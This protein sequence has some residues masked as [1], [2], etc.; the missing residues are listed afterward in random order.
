MKKQL[1][2][3]FAAVAVSTVF[4]QTASPSWS[5]SQNAAFTNTA[6]GIRIIDAVDANVVWL[7]G[8][9]GTAPS[10]NYSWFSRTTN[11]GTTFTAGTIF[12]DTNNYVI[13]NMEG[14]DAN[15]AWVCA[16]QHGAPYSVANPGGGGIF[17]TTNGGT[18][19]VN[20]AP[21]GMLT[22]TAQSFADFVSFLTPSVGIFVGD[23]VG[24]SYEIWRT[25]SGGN[26][27]TQVPA[28]AI[29]APVNST[30]FAITNL[31]CK[32]GNSNL[33]F[34]TN[35]GRVYRTTDGGSSWAVSQVAAPTSTI[36]QLAFTTPSV[37]LVYAYNGTTTELWN[38][39]DGG[40]TWAQVSPVPANMGL[41]DVKAIP[42]TN[43]YVSADGSQTAPFISYSSNNGATWTDFGSTGIQYLTLDFANPTSGWVGSFSDITT[44]SLGG[45]WKYSGTLTAT[46]VAPTSAFAVNPTLCGPTGAVTATN[47]ST[48]T[49]PLSYT[50]SVAPST[51]ATIS[52]STSAAPS[53]NFTAN[54]SYTLTLV[55]T[56]SVGTN[57]SSQ[58]VDVITC[59]APT[60]SFT[61]PTDACNLISF[62]TTVSGTPGSPAAGYL[63][64]ASPSA[65]VTF[66]PSPAVPNPSIKAIT[67]GTYTIT[68][69]ASNQS[70][71]VS[72]TQTVTVSDCKP[73]PSF[74]IAAGGCKPDTL[75]AANT[76]SNIAGTTVNSYTWTTAP[77]AGVVRTNTNSPTGQS[78]R[79]IFNNAN[80]YTI[81]LKA[82]NASGTAS[83]VQVI[84]VVACYV[85]IEENTNLANLLN[86]YPN[87][88]HDVLNIALP[89]STD[90]YTVKL[91]NVL[92]AVVYE[93]KT[94][95]TA[96]VSINLANKAKGVYFLN[97]ETNTEKVTKKVIVE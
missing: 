63:W 30:E 43:I 59:S 54:G 38:T 26:S 10:R 48:G 18:S 29:P 96:A 11:G 6:A 33:W 16:F 45:I 41:S 3:I 8:F 69:V 7:T 75:I 91:L 24:G 74:T 67:P 88:A 27:W 70:G 1:L 66:S 21:L 32:Q 57:S 78:S 40:V 49:G 86:V 12:A 85:G 77:T 72:T 14:V 25:T 50:W 64:T 5:I 9:D 31:Y 61:L 82:S 95:K 71:S 62:T 36:T 87:P 4:A 39:N 44:A 83:A 47:N 35:A 76:S 46:G 19:W 92:G 22:N 93:E 58:V 79:F 84:T 53:I 73:Q 81:T 13:A 28:A 37:G 97:V 80:T 51:G 56:N 20:M 60:A 68:Y 15:T 34:G 23:P 89:T 94:N 55:V 90:V 52:S 65:G 17:K 42:G 2:S